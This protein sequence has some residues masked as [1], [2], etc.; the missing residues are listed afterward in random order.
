MRR[1]H[2]ESE[3]DVATTVKAVVAGSSRSVGSRLESAGGSHGILASDS[4]TVNEERDG[5][6][7][8]PSLKGGSP[9]RGEEDDTNKH[10]NS[11]LN[12]SELACRCGEAGQ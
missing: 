9:D 2:E 5:V 7:G 3:N 8:D 4:D 12:E 10:D 11:V 6:G 1:T